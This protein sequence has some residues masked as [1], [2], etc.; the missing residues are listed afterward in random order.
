M[1]ADQDVNAA[2]QGVT[3]DGNGNPTTTS[4]A[5][6]P[7]RVRGR[8]ILSGLAKAAWGALTPF[9]WPNTASPTT[10]SA[11]DYLEG[12]AE[13]VASRFIDPVGNVV[14]L[15]TV[16][17]VDWLWKLDGAPSP[18]SNAK[19]AEYMQLANQIN[20]W[21]QGYPGISA[22]QFPNETIKPYP[23]WPN[24]DGTNV[25]LSTFLP[26]AANPNGTNAAGVIG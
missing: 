16:W 7:V 2:L 12:T 20:P 21:P 25:D 8:Q 14:N 13:Q 5:W 6:R 18:L 11:L 22:A 9:A 10:T 4:L 23:K 17:V 19:L 26:S 3:Q 1:P 24:T 15:F